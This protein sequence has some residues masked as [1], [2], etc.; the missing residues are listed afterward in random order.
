[1]EQGLEGGGG[2][3][4]TAPVKVT[5]LGKFRDMLPWEHFKSSWSEIAIKYESK[6]ILD[7]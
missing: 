5:K 4:K 7:K 6:T 1:M 2:G 3:E